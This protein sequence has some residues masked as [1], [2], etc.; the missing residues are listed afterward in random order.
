MVNIETEDGYSSNSLIP[1]QIGIASV[2]DPVGPDS[3]GY[4]IYGNE[5]IDYTLAPVYNW[6][7]I[8]DREGW[9]W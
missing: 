8:D 5:D 7:E 2:T 1:P 3:H 4:Y 6:V 9:S